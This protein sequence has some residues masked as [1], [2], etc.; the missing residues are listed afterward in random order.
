M[1]DFDAQP[2]LEP[3]QKLFALEGM[4]RSYVDNMDALEKD[5]AY[6]SLVDAILESPEHDYP[7]VESELVKMARL[8][9]IREEDLTPEALKYAYYNYGIYLERV[10]DT[11]LTSTEEEFILKKKEQ[12][13]FKSVMIFMKA[14]FSKSEAEQKA[15]EIRR[16]FPYKTLHKVASA[17]E[18]ALRALKQG[19]L[20]DS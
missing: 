11:P 12:Q 6:L 20:G 10:A 7:F 18:L 13:Y 16:K 4:I 3:R 14:E 19:F 8:K 5:R 2:D 15:E 1:T 9:G 17:T